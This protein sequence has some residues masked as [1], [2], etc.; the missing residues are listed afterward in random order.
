MNEDQVYSDYVKL[1]NHRRPYALYTLICQLCTVEPVTKESYDEIVK[2]NVETVWN[3]TIPFIPCIKKSGIVP[4]H[5]PYPTVLDTM[6]RLTEIGLYVSTYTQYVLMPGVHR[7]GDLSSD[8][9]GHVYTPR[10]W[11]VMYRNDPGLYYFVTC[12][13][14][15]EMNELR[16]DKGGKD[17]C[18]ALMTYFQ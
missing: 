15:D 2:S 6:N 1:I 16:K 3:A 13:M 8:V 5:L 4:Y 11:I 9:P 14:L 17:I 10:V 18:R 7:P 12:T